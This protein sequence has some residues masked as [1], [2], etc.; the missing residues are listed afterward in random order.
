MRFRVVLAL[1]VA[2]VVVSPPTVAALALPDPDGVL[3]SFQ[4]THTTCGVALGATLPVEGGCVMG[5]FSNS[6]PACAYEAGTWWDCV[7]WLNMSLSA[8]GTV[9]CGSA[10]ETDSYHDVSQE[11][12]WLCSGIYAQDPLPTLLPVGF[13]QVPRGGVNVTVTIDL[14]IHRADTSQIRCESYQPATIYLP[15]PQ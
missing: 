10:V 14:C 2:A 3:A 7:A 11:A 5:E 12:W 6:T 9:W 1:V 15:G 13:L 4:R 8:A